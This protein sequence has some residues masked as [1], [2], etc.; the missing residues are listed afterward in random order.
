MRV[1]GVCLALFLLVFDVVALV[2]F[3]RLDE[4][5]GVNDGY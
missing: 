2:W 3:R 5:T 4:R 1:F